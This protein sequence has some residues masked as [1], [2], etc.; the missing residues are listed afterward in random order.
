MAID[1][2]KL[3][4]EFSQG[5]FVQK[6]NVISGDL[7]PYMGR[8][9]AVHRGLGCL[10]VQ[11]P[12]GN[13]RVFPDDI[14]AVDPKFSRVLPPA[15][16][17]QTYMTVEIEKAR[18]AATASALWRTASFQPAVYVDLA[19]YWHNRVSEVLAYDT[20]YRA[21]EPNVADDQL[22]DEVSK[23]YRFASNAGLMFVQQVAESRSFEN[24]TAAY[25]IAQNRTY[26]ATGEDLK[27][28]KP[29][30]PKCANRMRR[31]TYK[32]HKGMKAKVFACPKCLTLIDP[33]SILGPDGNPHSWF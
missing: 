13:E 6:I 23:F 20:L 21:L 17:D 30:C 25:W 28:G 16:L 27:M 5:D 22:R 8:V 31:A 11:W 12:F 3:T 7:S 26:R 15:L 2:W 1:Y 24:K 9:T 33:E 10:D 32:M 29:A 14:V 19:R 4:R 18:K